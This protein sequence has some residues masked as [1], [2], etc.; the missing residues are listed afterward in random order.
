M[1]YTKK[2]EISGEKTA[3]SQDLDE[4]P[5]NLRTGRPS[6]VRV[7]EKGQACNPAQ[8]GLLGRTSQPQ[9]HK[10]PPTYCE[11]GVLGG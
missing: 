3:P 9:A 6:S 1:L 4:G 11:N 5:P 7:V 2:I 10:P 8:R